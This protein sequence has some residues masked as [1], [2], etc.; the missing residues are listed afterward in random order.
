MTIIAV[1]QDSSSWWELE[2]NGQLLNQQSGVETA[3]FNSGKASLWL[4]PKH[5]LHFLLL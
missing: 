2:S 1:I 4:N 3:H 5:L